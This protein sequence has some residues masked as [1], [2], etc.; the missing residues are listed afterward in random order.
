MKQKNT[1]KLWVLGAALVCVATTSAA[2]S[3]GRVRGAVLLGQPLSLTVAVQ[4][5]STDPAVDLCFDADV[6]YGDSRQ[7]AGQITV[8]PI[9][10][11]SGAL[12]AVRVSVAVP[13]D[14]PI[15]TMY[16]RSGCSQKTSR[17]Y[18]LLS[19]LASDLAP[20]LP[21]ESVMRPTR[22]LRPPVLFEPSGAASVA[23]APPDSGKFNIGKSTQASKR[24]AVEVVKPEADRPSV[25]LK[26]STPSK[27]R[28]KLSNLDYVESKDPNLKLS[29]ALTSVPS[30][31]A[32][33]R[34]AAVALWRS[35]NTSPQDWMQV[36]A[37]QKAL[38]DDLKS[39]RD[40]SL[41]NQQQWQ[42]MSSRLQQAESARYANP[43]V[44]ALCAL[45]LMTGLTLTALTLKFR[46]SGNVS[47]W[48]RSDS[49]GSADGDV[50]VVANAPHVDSG[51]LLSP[52]EQ[53]DTVGDIAVSVSKAEIPTSA[54][55]FS[56]SGLDI[57]L[58]L[59]NPAPA[60]LQTRQPVR[61][62][63]TI[64]A[65]S[66]IPAVG[67]PG[68]QQDLSH[69]L[70]ASLHAINTHEMLDVRQQAD[71]FMTLGQHEEAIALLEGSIRENAASNPL[72]FLDLLKVLHT[73]SRKPAFDYYRTEFNEI[74]TGRVQAYATFGQPGNSLDAYPQI[75]GEIS[76]LWC[77]EAAVVFLEQCMVRSTVDAPEMHF[78]LEAFRDLLLLHAVAGRIILNRVSD[79]GV[80]PFSAV[81]T[82]TN[83]AVDGF[84]PATALDHS[85]KSDIQ[86]PTLDL[87]REDP[88]LI[89]FDASGITVR[90]PLPEDKPKKR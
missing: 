20:L 12:S 87:S 56:N 46:G 82:T 35:L 38:S 15:V 58:D 39:L 7:D 14:E 62:K 55:D 70:S 76:E 86:M 60:G 41:K 47:P 25:V 80:M 13:V 85:G 31:D 33:T 21:S 32:V 30:E 23:L 83:S 71:F 89:D 37:Q 57:D 11:E 88:N 26:P 61:R 52:V 72:V 8:A 3:L 36:E 2:L 54:L 43:L 44:Y 10:L 73:L 67:F 79:S 19:D 65:I 51:V 90:W 4:A 6:F 59:D 75:C 40:I 77:T 81:K 42:E 84:S 74:F 64:A 63:E 48:W 16:L 1:K 27:S 78:D 50:G 45:L 28:L 69:S 53:Q 22:E 24:S 68:V 5:D 18:V 17:K 9:R 49:Q 34:D 29:N 66:A